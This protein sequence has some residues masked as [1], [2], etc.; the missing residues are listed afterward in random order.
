M[1]VWFACAELAPL[2]STG[3]LGE[4]TGALSK[5]LSQLGCDVSVV[6][7]YYLTTEKLNLKKD[8]FMSDLWA[9]LGPKWLNFDVYKVDKSDNLRIFLIKRE[10]FYF[11]PNLYRDSKGDYYDNFERFC[12]F[13]HAAIK[14]LNIIDQRKDIIHCHDWHTGLLCA[15]VR[16][17]QL[18]GD[19]N[20]KIVF[21]VHNIAYQ[22]IYPKE[23]FY[24]T[25]LDPNVYFTKE[26]MEFWGNI[27]L[28]KAGV[29]YADIITTV[30]PNHAQ[31]LKDNTIA[32]GLEGLFVKREGDL[33]GI[34]N[35]VDYEV[36]DPKTDKFIK[37]NFDMKDLRGKL[38]CKEDLLLEFGLSPSYMNR[39]TIGMVSR[40][41]V[42]KGIDLI[43]AA[44]DRIMELDISLVILGSGDQRYVDGL[45]YFKARYPEKIGLKITHDERLAHKVVAGSD[46]ILVPSLFEPCGI[47]QMYA[48]R[49]GTI[50][51]ARATGG[52]KD[53][54]R[55]FNPS[56]MEGNGFLFEH[57]DTNG[58]L[59]A[60]T[61]A[62]R[63]YHWKDLWDRIVSNALECD[64]SWERSA[65]EY[66]GLYEKLME[67][68]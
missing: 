64:F 9:Q 18:E 1:H 53:T 51:I 4:V 46:M 63:F 29:V 11:R 54:V 33:V 14:F 8:L 7:P 19:T 48:L 62:L 58:L 57:F 45:N 2:A 23:K 61:Q 47:V 5:K 42:Q 43:L 67:R 3:G 38:L 25:G 27:N 35:G 65:K 36:W 60:I 32:R 41:D 13:C 39:P 59:W 12:F 56:T 16:A 55:P 52:L 10:D 22:G 24:L 37:A 17:G 68:R 21:T 28:M 66:L 40:L 31:E 49:Y 34:L 15:L 44:M 50:P 20:T 30:S 26:G 6:M